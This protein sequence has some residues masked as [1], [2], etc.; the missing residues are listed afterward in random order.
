M[1]LPFE[2]LTLKES[3]MLPQIQRIGDC[4][5][6]LTGSSFSTKCCQVACLFEA[7]LLPLGMPVVAVWL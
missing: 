1:L 7:N 3:L 2:A 4:C 5:S 6:F